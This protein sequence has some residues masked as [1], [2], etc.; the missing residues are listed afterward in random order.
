MPPDD[1]RSRL[2][3]IRDALLE[4]PE[5]NYAELRGRSPAEAYPDDV[6]AFREMAN[7][8]GALVPALAAYMAERE[9]P[10]LRSVLQEAVRCATDSRWVALLAKQDPIAWQRFGDVPRDLALAIDGVL[11]WVDPVPVHAEPTPAA[12]V[13]PVADVADG[14]GVTIPELRGLTGVTNDTLNKYAKRAGLTTARPG[15]RNFCYSPGDAMK[16]VQTMLAVNTENATRER[17]QAAL[18]QLG[19]IRKKPGN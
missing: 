19:Q 2:L 14:P 6:Q 18:A 13:P 15:Q 9:A 10:A 3:T 5:R 7:Q 17:C 16:L 11:R 8:L 4:L 1:L 12:D